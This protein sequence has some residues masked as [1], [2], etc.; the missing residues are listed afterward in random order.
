MVELKGVNRLISSYLAG[1]MG[2][3]E[4]NALAYRFLNVRNSKNIHWK[5][6][7]KE[8]IFFLIDLKFVIFVLKF[9][10]RNN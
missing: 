3:L 4:W 5:N 8:N 10:S 9:F 7:K 6:E 2:N 1:I